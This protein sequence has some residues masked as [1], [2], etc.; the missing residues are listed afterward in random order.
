MAVGGASP[1]LQS[2]L[3]EDS[4]GPLIQTLCQKAGIQT[5]SITDAISAGNTVM[6]HSFAGAKLSGFA[7]YPFAPEFVEAQKLDS[8]SIGFP[9][10]FPLELA[11]NLGPFVGADIAV[12][13]LASGM[14]EL[15]GPALLI[16]F[17]TNGEILLKTDDGY[18]ATATAARPAFEGGRF[19]TGL[20][21][22]RIR[23]PLRLRQ[24]HGDRNDAR[25]RPGSHPHHRQC[26][27]WR[28][29]PSP[30]VRQRS[31]NRNTS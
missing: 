7:A 21:R 26:L 9:E 1:D 3:V 6:Q 13:A 11:A 4:L 2:S 14:L 10:S 19:G 29:L 31:R 30:S 22:R 18:L 25:R 8:V 17:G 12:G 23:L 24:C 27:A 5:S 20:H 15:D 16:D 28:R